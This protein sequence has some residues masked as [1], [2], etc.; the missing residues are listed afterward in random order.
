MSFLVHFKK[1]KHRIA[2]KQALFLL[3]ILMFIA[4]P[5]YLEAAHIVGGEMT[6][7]F[8]RRD[9]ANPMRITYRF[10]MLVYRD[11]ASTGSGLDP[12]VSIGTYLKRPNGISVFVRTRI[13]SLNPNTRYIPR[14]SLPCS[15]TPSNIGV[16]EG[17]YE[18]EE[19]LIDTSNSGSAYIVAWQRCCRNNTIGNINSP[20]AAG[21]AYF[22]EISP[23]SQRSNNS[24]PT[25][26]SLPPIFICANEPLNYN[27]SAIDAEGDQ[28]VYKFCP[29]YSSGSQQAPVP[30]PTTNLPPFGSVSYRLPTYS[31]T[32]PMGGN[33]V[34]KIDPNTGVITGTPTELTQMVVTICAEEY[35]N[36]VLIGQVFRDF[37][38]NVVSCRRL[39][40]TAVTADSSSVAAKKYVIFGCENVR[41]NIDNRSYERSAIN[42][43]K[44]IFRFGNRDSVFT[45]WSPSIVFRDTGIY[46]GKLILNDPEQPCSDSAFV[47]VRVGGKI[48]PNFSFKYDTCEAGPVKVKNTT[49]STLPLRSFAWNFG[50]NSLD[51]NKTETQFQYTTPGFKTIKLN[52]VDKFGCKGDTSQSFFWQPAPPILIVE[53]DNFT[54][55]APAKVRFTNKSSPIDSTYKIVWTF[56]DGTTGNQ[57][58]P[59]HIYAKPDTYSVKLQIT[60][61]LNCYKEA[62]FRSWIKVKSVPKADFDYSPKVINNLNPSVSFVDRSSS[63]V[64][65]WRWFFD[66]KAYSAMKNPAFTYKDTGVQKV[67]L[68]VRNANGCQ[69]SIFKTL[70]IEPEVTFHFPTAFTPN[71]DSVNDI[72][73]GAGFLFG[74]KEYTLTIWNRWGEVVFKSSDP[75][76]GWNGLK[77]NAGL[78]VPAG[79]YMFD[80]RYTTPKNKLIQKRDYLTLY[81]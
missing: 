38:F 20:Q 4:P 29:A 18:W 43:W 35:R 70:I 2:M 42:Q 14:P 59:T 16:L 45:D 21:S 39:V 30:S 77:N 33:P 49:I 54:G 46:R 36:G 69:D 79:V 32:Q 61:P 28:I 78:Q 31:A 50:E 17:K 57:I 3:L 37:Q 9:T 44:W 52:A 51:S 25:F 76:E 41:L 6:Y 11:S 74:I 58:S 48:F 15:E 24:S 1:T 64:I 7:K 72:F 65:A 27:H 55:C 66:N 40:V 22:V 80:V 60:S 71:D 10:T 73:K 26:R 56:G 12:T 8:I 68:F 23:E 13:V 19:T 53:P 5:Q 47:E 34:V 67:Q 63:D 81:R 62:T 75:Q